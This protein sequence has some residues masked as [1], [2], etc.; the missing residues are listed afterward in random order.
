[1]TNII[2][3]PNDDIEIDDNATPV[4]APADQI[5]DDDLVEPQMSE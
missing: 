4:L 5:E 3:E 2:P 1:M